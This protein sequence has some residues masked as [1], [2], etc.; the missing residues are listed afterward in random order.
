MCFSYFLP[1]N[2]HSVFLFDQ[3]PTQIGNWTPQ[4]L[5]QRGRAAPRRQTTPREWSFQLRRIQIGDW[6][7]QQNLT[8]SLD[9]LHHLHPG[10]NKVKYNHFTAFLG[11]PSNGSWICPDLKQTIVQTHLH[12]AG[13]RSAFSRRVMVQYCSNSDHT[14]LDEKLNPI[15]LLQFIFKRGRKHWTEAPMGQHHSLG[16]EDFK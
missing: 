1:C 2:F 3:L 14:L 8:S 6:L 10:W 15:E 11:I 13:V 16:F 5:T 9:H 4:G 7:P 12:S